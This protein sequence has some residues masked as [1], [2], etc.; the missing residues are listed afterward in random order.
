MRRAQRTCLAAVAAYVVGAPAEAAEGLRPDLQCLALTVYHESR[1]ES[2]AGKLAVA[3]VVIN[4][5][6]DRRF[7]A[8]ICDVVYQHAKSHPRAC[9][10]SWTCDSLGDRPMNLGA[11]RQ[12]VRIARQAFFGLAEDPTGGA[13][14]Y[15]ADYVKPKWAARLGSPQQIGRHLFYRHSVDLAA[16]RAVPDST[17]AAGMPTEPGSPLPDATRDFLKRLRIT[18]I[19]YAADPESRIVRINSAMY[20]QGDILSPDLTLASVTSH[21]VVLRYRDRW[22]RFVL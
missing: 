22:F 2:E 5:A 8:Q 3:H 10:F 11:W 6:R 21:A 20:R 17:F 4:R 1:G 14:W 9:E 16:T 13:L 15:H 19:H 12:S 7:P 18:M